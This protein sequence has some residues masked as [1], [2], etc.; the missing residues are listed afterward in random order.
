ML[1]IRQLG[2]LIVSKVISVSV[3]VS[4]LFRTTLP[5]E[6]PSSLTLF[7]LLPAT[8]TMPPEVRG[9]LSCPSVCLS[10]GICGRCPGL[11][12]S[13]RTQHSPEPLSCAWLSRTDVHQAGIDIRVEC[14][15]LARGHANDEERVYGH[16]SHNRVALADDVT[17]F[18][19]IRL[20]MPTSVLRQYSVR[21]P[22]W[23][24]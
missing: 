21:S 16:A 8:S 24:G 17:I 7:I 23:R 9:R 12:C 2:L 20:A 4:V 15:N 5:M 14:T 3:C 10:P 11:S 19:S 13:C 18:S 22:R 6:V 1:S